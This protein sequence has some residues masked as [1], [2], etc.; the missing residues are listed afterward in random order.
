MLGR[1]LESA[2]PAQYV[3]RIVGP[4]E[5]G[6]REHLRVAAA[7][8]RMLQE[9]G[10]HEQLSQLA[11]RL[12]PQVGRRRR[13]TGDRQQGTVGFRELPLNRRM[14]PT[15]VRQ[16]DGLQDPRLARALRRRARSRFDANL[17]RTGEQAEHDQ[18]RHNAAPQVLSDAAW[19]TV[20][21]STS[22]ASAPSPP[23]R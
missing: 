1:P 14:Q 19:Q 12:T 13:I 11:V 21:S 16:G 23:S 15:G 20:H 2:H 10:G 6:R 9:L 8:L 7:P 22:G 17:R 18:R 4:S 5:L 3:G